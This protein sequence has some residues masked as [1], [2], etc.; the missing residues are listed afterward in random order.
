MRLVRYIYI[1][2][3]FVFVYSGCTYKNKERELEKRTAELNER[4]QQ[5]VLKEQTLDLRSQALDEREKV[6][7]ST[8]KKIANDS[9]FVRYPELPGLWNVKMTCTETNCSGSAIGDTKNE[10][11]DFNFQNNNV[12]ISAISNNK[13]VRVYSGEIN[14]NTL[15]LTLSRDTPDSLSSSMSIRLQLISEKEMTGEREI[16]QASGCRIVYSLVLKKQ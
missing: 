4:E 10:K 16:I 11:W 3:F 8:S 2:L 14:D 1:I 6:L 9:L 7:D 15:K 12:I 5:L 13:L